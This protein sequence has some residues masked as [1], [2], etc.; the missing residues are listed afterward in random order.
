MGGCNASSLLQESDNINAKSQHIQVG[1]IRRIYRRS[2]R[3]LSLLG[4]LAVTFVIGTIKFQ[5]SA[6]CVAM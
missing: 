6:H 5:A 4:A 2:G 1:E 3:K